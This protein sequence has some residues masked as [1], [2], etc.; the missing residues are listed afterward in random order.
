MIGWGSV[1]V[2]RVLV[3]VVIGKIRS[4]QPLVADMEKA[5]TVGYI[6]EKEGENSS[7]L[8]RDESLGKASRIY[9]KSLH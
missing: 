1:N 6:R 7:K 2:D 3:S 9:F 8:L 4:I 5:G